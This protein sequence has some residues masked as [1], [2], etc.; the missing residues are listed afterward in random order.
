MKLPEWETVQR[1]PS[2]FRFPGGES[3]SEMQTRAFGAVTE[4][5][6]AHRGESVVL[7][8]HADPIK[9][10]VAAAV[11][12]PR[13]LFQRLVISPCSITTL[14]FSRQGVIVLSVN[15]TPSLSELVPS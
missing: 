6:D 5:A 13:D 4:I 11:G 7:V 2:L 8:S 9:A 15:T 1:A 10:I 3:F 14:G 12:T